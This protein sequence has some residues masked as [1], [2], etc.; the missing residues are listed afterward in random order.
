MVRPMIASPDI[1]Y[2]VRGDTSLAYQ[3]VGDGPVDVLEVSGFFTHLEV[4]WET[5][6]L[7]GWISSMTR[8]SRLIMYDRRGVGLSER[9]VLR[10]AAEPDVLAEDALAVLDAAGSRQAVVVGIG[11]GGYAA[12]VLAALH[13]ERVRALVLYNCL[14]LIPHEESSRRL[15]SLV[16][17]LR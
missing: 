12:C 6:G 16:D 8:F 17:V 11:D 10:A 7:L 3:V 5:P 1:R 2:L 15:A 14:K 4:K 13:P 9:D